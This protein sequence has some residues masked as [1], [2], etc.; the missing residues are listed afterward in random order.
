MTIKINL[1]C[2]LIISL[3]FQLVFNAVENSWFSTPRQ[4]RNMT[5]DKLVCHG[6]VFPKVRK[7]YL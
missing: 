1:L 3:S 4:L 6:T 7:M 5:D 2:Q